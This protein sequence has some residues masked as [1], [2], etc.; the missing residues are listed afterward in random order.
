MVTGSIDRTF[1]GADWSPDGSALVLAA[2]DATTT[3]LW[4][5]PLDGAARRIALGELEPHD[6]FVGAGGSIA[7]V[8]V[9]PGRPSELYLLASPAA[10]PRRLTD[11]NA[12]TAALSLGKTESVEWKVTGYQADGVITLPPS[13]QPGTKYPLLLVIHGGP[14]GSSKRAF[15]ELPQLLAARGWVIFEPNYRGSDNLGNGY[16]SAIIG[17]AG[18]GPGKDV[19]AG[20]ATLV[21]RGLVDTTRIGVSGWSY[22]GYMT[23]W[24][25]G[26]YP[27]WRAALAGAALT[28]YGDSYNLSDINVTFGGGWG[29]SVWQAPYD[30]VVRDQSPT[31]YF[32]R[33]NTPTLILSNTGDVRVPIVQSYK[34]YHA[35]KDRGVP[36]KFVAYPIPGHFARDPVRVR[37]VYRRWIGWF[38]EHF[39]S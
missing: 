18:D 25:I 19:M 12:P 32:G 21:A 9:E 33:I 2:S 37:D 17:D 15:S 26:H 22:G 7:F 28:D 39:G 8:G 4:W 11:Y 5:V 14:M 38:E 16:Q 23:T 20:I 29:G 1:Y 30:K 34:L 13:Y 27:R 6:L 10:E 36:V 35:L 3:S 31:S 24:L